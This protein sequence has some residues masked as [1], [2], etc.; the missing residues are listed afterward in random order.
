MEYRTLGKTGLR[1][2]AVSLGLWAASGDA[3]GP[4]PGWLAT[5]QQAVAAWHACAEARGR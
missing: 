3:W 2:S 5:A 4:G 1:V